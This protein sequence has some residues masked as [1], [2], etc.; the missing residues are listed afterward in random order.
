MRR[1][2]LCTKLPYTVAAETIANQLSRSKRVESKRLSSSRQSHPIRQAA[3]Q[4][5]TGSCT[6]MPRRHL[7]SHRA[8]KMQEDITRHVAAAGDRG[9][10]WR[11]SAKCIIRSSAYTKAKASS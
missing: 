2:R 4:Q 10:D 11:L 5:N 3:V 9:R 7:L 6:N 1:R 8:A